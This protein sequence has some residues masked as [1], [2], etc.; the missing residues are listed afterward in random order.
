MV[1]NEKLNKQVSGKAS[2]FAVVMGCFM[3]L[4]CM[5][6]SQVVIA[7]TQPEVVKA[8]EEV[9]VKPQFPGGDAAMYEFIGSNMVYPPA[10]VEKGIQGRV[11]VRFV[12]AETGDIENIEVL[13]CPDASLA[14]EAVRL[15]K[16]MPKWEPGKQGGVNVPVY[17]MLPLTFRF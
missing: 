15:V 16:S 17:F 14:D 4:M 11:V 8:F 6:M 13:R 3:V 2:F 5:G 7:Q 9:D 1:L 12:V 10:A